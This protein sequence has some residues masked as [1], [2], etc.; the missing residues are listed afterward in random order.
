MPYPIYIISG[1]TA[2]GK[3]EFA[4]RLANK[5]NGE[6][7]NADS[8]QVYSELSL[9]TS[10]P[11]R[12]DESF[13]KHHL[14]GHV[15]GN[16]RY[17]VYSWCKDVEKIVKKN[18][19]KKKHS[20]IV[21]G[22]GL[23]IDTIINGISEIPQVPESYKKKSNKFFIEN[24]HEEFYK[25]VNSIDSVACSKIDK[26]D[27]QRLKRIWEIHSFTGK[28]HTAWIKEKKNF[29]L[30][31]LI[32]YIYLFFPERKYIYKKIDDR[33]VQMIHDGAIDEVKNLLVLNIDKSLPIMK[34]HGVPEI[35]DYLSGLISF[36]EC[37]SKGQQ[38][39]RNYAKRQITWWNSS[40]LEIQR[41]YKDFPKNIDINSLNFEKN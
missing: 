28:N 16:S 3:S 21:G 35:C 14:Y 24:G 32:F 36:D 22:T 6:I 25:I 27:I 7:I 4:I 34:A 10:R 11:S 13:I 23:Y 40:N 38:V 2:V 39:T 37:I 5:I 29:F 41:I 8:M 17:N 19:D 1:P 26:N 12:R 18:I 20:I 15:S 30:K 9:L 33:F 31:D